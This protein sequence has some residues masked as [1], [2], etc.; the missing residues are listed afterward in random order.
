MGRLSD[1]FSAPCA[2]HPFLLARKVRQK[3]HGKP[4]FSFTEVP[5]ARAGAAHFD[6]LADAL[7]EWAGRIPC[8]EGELEETEVFGHHFELEFLWRCCEQGP[9]VGRRTLEGDVKLSWE[10]SRGYSHVVNAMRCRTPGEKDACAEKVATSIDRWTLHNANPDGTNWQVAMEVGIRAFNWICADALLEGRLARKLGGAVFRQWIWNH[11]RAIWA[12]LEYSPF[13]VSNHYTADLL[14]LAA[15]GLYLSDLPTGRKWLRF[16]RQEM[17]SSILRHQTHADGGLRENS[18]RYHCLVTEMG[19]HFLALMQ[20]R[21]K[22]RFRGRLVAMCKAVA[23]YRDS[24]SGDVFAFGDDDGGRIVPL[25]FVSAWGRADTLLAY[26][27]LQLGIDPGVP[28]RAMHP[29][30]G[31]AALRMGDFEL[32]VDYGPVCGAHAHNDTLSFCVNHR[33][34]PVLVD[35]G[36]GIYTPDLELRNRLRGMSHHSVVQLE[37]TCQGKGGQGNLGAFYMEGPP[38]SCRIESIEH[39]LVLVNGSPGRGIEARHRRTLRVDESR[40]VLFIEDVLSG[41]FRQATWR[42]VLHPGV[43]VEVVGQGYRLAPAGG[44]PLL[45]TCDQ[46]LDFRIEA[47]VYSPFYGRVEET[48]IC[49]AAG[50]SAGTVRWELRQA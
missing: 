48:R 3:M 7:R 1:F 21:V 40:G 39:G 8:P 15:V 14:G 23:A 47:G 45:L 29:D 5:P 46:P 50:G 36:S 20:S 26:A 17:Q 12:R 16:A 18:L 37:D 43:E 13:K 10:F 25:D 42:F 24:T 34:R 4:V 30:S 33:G 11:G 28:A 2:R 44:G 27:Q 22:P 49:A 9:V 35:P 6:M 31:W 19:L 38:R 32:A 41:S